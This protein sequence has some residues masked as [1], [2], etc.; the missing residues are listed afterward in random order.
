M[1]EELGAGEPRGRCLNIV[2]LEKCWRAAGRELGALRGEAWSESN[3]SGG[4]GDKTQWW[5]P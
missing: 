5:C 4:R 3:C 2:W 1:E